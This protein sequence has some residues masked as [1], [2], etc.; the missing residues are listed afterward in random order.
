MCIDSILKLRTRSLVNQSCFMDLYCFISANN[1]VITGRHYSIFFFPALAVPLTLDLAGNIILCWQ[2]GVLYDQMAKTRK[3]AEEK[4]NII[5]RTVN[6]LLHEQ[7][8]LY[9]CLHSLL[10]FILFMANGLFSFLFKG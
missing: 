9:H 2:R 5:H 4:I 1:M 6:A 3:I 7:I 8:Q 10:H